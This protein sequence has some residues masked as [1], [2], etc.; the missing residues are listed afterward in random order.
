MIL[1]LVSQKGGVGKSTLA[2]S[3]AW[4]LQARGARVLA[5]D[6]DPQG[7]LRVTGEV[8]AELGLKAPSIVALGKDLY[9]P[10]QL[11]QLAK[12]FDHVVI[13]TP[14]R[15]GDVQRAALMVA[16]VALV[17]VGQSA[18]DTWGV[19][20][21]LEV[22]KQ[23]QILRPELRAVLVLTRKLPRTALGRAA[24]DVL[25]GAG[26]PLL[27]AET[28]LRVAWQEALAAGAGVAQY[29][30]Q[31]AAALELRDLVDELVALHSSATE[32]LIAHG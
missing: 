7:T 10:D 12:A 18:A 22:V 9:R 24:R 30:P 26:L 16:D 3:I 23:A 8:A 14:G 19:T 4:E 32:R 25:A 15:L 1:A 13:D 28:T 29:A 20:E 17:P 11:P 21:T 6:A 2:V 27:T 31:D 5:V